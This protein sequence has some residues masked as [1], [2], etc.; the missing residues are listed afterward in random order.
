VRGDKGSKLMGVSRCQLAF[1]TIAR[2]PVQAIALGH[3][4]VLATI[5]IH[6]ARSAFLAPIALA[7]GHISARF[8]SQTDVAPDAGPTHSGTPL[9][10]SAPEVWA[11][12]PEV[13]ERAF[14][15]RLR[16]SLAQIRHCRV[17][18]LGVMY[19]FSGVYS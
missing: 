11:E 13:G 9:L 12:R 6:V 8:L 16:P 19:V 5:L 7:F 3:I 18:V 15:L 17:P 1:G 14:R 2:Q 4:F 10:M